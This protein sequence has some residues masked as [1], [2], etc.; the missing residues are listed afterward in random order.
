M[1]KRAIMTATHVVLARAQE[2]DRT[3]PADMLGDVHGVADVVG[4]GRGATPETAARGQRLDFHVFRLAT[5]D[6]RGVHLV[7]RLA[8]RAVGELDARALHLRDAVHRLQRRV[9]KVGKVVLERMHLAAGL[10]ELR[11]RIA[12][13]LERHPGGIAL[14]GGDRLVVRQYFAG[15]SH[16]GLGVVPLASAA[17]HGLSLPRKTRWPRSRRPTGFRT[18]RRRRAPPWRPWRR[19]S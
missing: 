3:E 1:R 6:G 17:R 9:R 11:R 12:L 13:L 18:R 19:N 15:G 8:L 14:A 10:G 16:L 2:F 4:G 7:D 5:D